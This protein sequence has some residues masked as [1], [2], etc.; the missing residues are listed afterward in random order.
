MDKYILN[1][2]KQINIMD[3]NEAIRNDLYGAWIC[4]KCGAKH[5]GK[6]PKHCRK[7]GNKT[8][9]KRKMLKR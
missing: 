9:R 1:I 5:R 3:I 8:F 6:K 4:F 7:C 2:L